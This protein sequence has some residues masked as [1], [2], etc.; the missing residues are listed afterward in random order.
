MQKKHFW[1]RGTAYFLDLLIGGLI[2][3]MTILLLNSVF[4]LN[5]LAPELI[6]SRTCA[7]T[8]GLVTPKRM[9][10]LLPLRE[11]Q[12]HQQIIC[13]Q[14][15]MLASSYY[16]TMLQ[17]V[18][19]EGNTN[20]SVHISY[21]SDEFGKQRTY[22][23]SE[24]FFYLLAPLVFALCLAKWGQTP[25]KWLLYLIVYNNR[26][27]RPDLKSALK[28]EYF[29]AIIFVGLALT[30][31]YS[32]YQLITFDLDEAATYVQELLVNFNQTNFWVWMSFAIVLT[33]GGFWFQFG[34]FIRWRGRT[35]WD[36]F[37]DL[38]TS[39]LK[40]LDQRKEED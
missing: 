28:R 27:E 17:K 36:Q 35:F 13:K 26:F 37:A 22:I 34:S 1:R 32:L 12:Q 38:N 7:L 15:N 2:V 8:G 5:I 10:E 23:P 31:L 25:G 11:G 33:I 4:S 18:W 9:N 39:T 21:H 14:T 29:K 6:S 3:T 20:Y 30:S 19:K 16:V 24:P 40:E